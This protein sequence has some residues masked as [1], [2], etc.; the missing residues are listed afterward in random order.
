MRILT[1]REVDSIPVI[2]RTAMSV[3]IVI[4]W[5]RRRVHSDGSRQTATVASM[6]SSPSGPLPRRQSLVN[7][8]SAAHATIAE[9]RPP[10]TTKASTIQSGR[11]VAPPGL[12]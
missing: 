6:R 3:V 8:S 11:S 9:P 2:S 4:E 1:S 12:S 7:P 10:T 5:I